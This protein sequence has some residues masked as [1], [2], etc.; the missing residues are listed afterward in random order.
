MAEQLAESLGRASLAAQTSF[1]SSKADHALL[2][3]AEEW[4]ADCIFV[5]AHAL[6]G[7]RPHALGGLAFVA[8]N[9]AHCTV[10]IVR[11]GDS[12]MAP[13]AMTQFRGGGTGQRSRCA[14]WAFRPEP[15]APPRTPGI[16]GC[17]EIRLGATRR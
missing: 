8:V 14:R 11:S 1:L 6:I 5:S 4:E 2:R 10:E 17:G 16:V 9:L 3:S 13:P 7:G 15:C 12:R